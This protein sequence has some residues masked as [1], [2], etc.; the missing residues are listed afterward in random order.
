[1]T[2]IAIEVGKAVALLAVALLCLLTG[3][4]AAAGRIPQMSTVFNQPSFAIYL[5]YLLPTFVFLAYRQMYSAP[6]YQNHE[7]AAIQWV[8]TWASVAAGVML[9]VV[10]FAPHVYWMDIAAALLLSSPLFYYCFESYLLYR[11]AKDPHTELD[12]RQQ[13]FE[14]Q[15]FI[16]AFLLWL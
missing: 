8:V 6:R 14:N 2:A 12:R 13:G 4:V 16:P 1:M 11:S 15:I 10:L 9:I 3:M 7:T 5:V